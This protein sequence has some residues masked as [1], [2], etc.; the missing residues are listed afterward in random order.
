MTMV[1][2]ESGMRIGDALKGTVYSRE[3]GRP[4]PSSKVSS[5]F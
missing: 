3:E 4:S 1:P 2:N 5:G